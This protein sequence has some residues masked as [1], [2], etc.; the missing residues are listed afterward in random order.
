MKNYSLIRNKLT[1]SPDRLWTKS[2]AFS[3][4]E[5]GTE[6]ICTAAS[7]FIYLF[8]YY[9]LNNYRFGGDSKKVTIF[10]QSAGGFSVGLIILS[11]LATGLYQNVILQSG[12]PSALPAFLE[13]DQAELRAR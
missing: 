5:L 8:I 7:I 2:K 4:R 6:F 9:L 13:K 11:P 3:S 12:A 10:G 1:S